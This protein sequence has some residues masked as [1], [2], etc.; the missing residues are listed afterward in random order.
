MTDLSNNRLYYGSRDPLPEQIPLRAGPLTMII[1]N[2]DLRYLQLGMHEIVRRLYVAIRDRNWNT[3]ANVLTDVQMA[4]EEDHFQISYICTN[5]LGDIDFVWQG[6]LV[7]APDGTITCTM[8]GEARSTFQRNRIGFCLLHPNAIAGANGRITHVDGTVE[9]CS[10]PLHIAP[11]LIIDGTI[12]PVSPFDEMRGIAHEIVPGIWAE[13]AFRGDI[14]EMEDQRNWTDASYKSYGTPLRLP[15]PVTVEAGT[16]IEQQVTIQLVRAHGNSSQIAIDDASPV[17]IAP[18]T[19]DSAIDSRTD[20]TAPITIA[21]TTKQTA[22]P[23]I[24]LG[25]ASHGE[26][27]QTNEIERLRSLNLAHLRVDLKLSEAQFLATLQRATSEAQA[28]GIPLEVAVHVT[29]NADQELASL[30]TELHTLKP[31]VARWLIFHNREKTTTAPWVALA[32]QH[33]ATYAPDVPIGAGT[34]VYFT[35]LNSRRPPIEALDVVAYSINPQIH[36]FDNSSLIETVAAQATTATSA[37]QFC[38]DLPLVVSPV[39][40]Q[41]RFNPNATGPEAEPAPGQLPPQVDP[42]QMSLFGA[43][44]TLGSIKYLAESGEIASITYYETTGWRGVM[45]RP[46]GSPL[47]HKFPSLPGAVFPLYHLLADVGE[48]SGGTVIQCV[49]TE[50]RKVDTL[51]LQKEGQQRLLLANMTAQTQEVQVQGLTG[52]YDIRELN[53]MNAQQAMQHPAEFRVVDKSRA[54]SFSDD[55]TLPPFGVVCCDF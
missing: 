44:W 52:T 51:L 23:Q 21:V 35:E 36:A 1:E 16:K 18:V 14:F 40:L 46:A 4:I 37:R 39:T 31:T 42:R 7:G 17:V 30:V 2:G 53:E 11:Q 33:L 49:S 47:P 20:E 3:A 50:P 9:E 8:A 5:Q 38:G 24:G 27:L 55:I 10:F 25:L 28:L 6:T 32:R 41:P 34:N 29:D 43:G 26:A 22:L 13:V 54:A 19:T 45:E 48:F 12:K 15:F